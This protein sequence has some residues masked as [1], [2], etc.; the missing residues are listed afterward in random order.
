MDMIDV[1]AGGGPSGSVEPV[2]RTLPMWILDL[3]QLLQ[4]RI[5]AAL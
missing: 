5:R 1:L 3:M 2:H 4:F